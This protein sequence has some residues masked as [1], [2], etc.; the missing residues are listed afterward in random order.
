MWVNRKWLDED[1]NM[2]P[3]SKGEGSENPTLFNTVYFLLLSKQ[4]GGLTETER[5]MLILLVKDK[6]FTNG[7]K[8]KTNNND[9]DD[10]FSLDESMAVATASLLF[11]TKE[12][13]DKLRIVTKQTWFRFYDVI[14]YLLMCKY[15]WTR[16]FGVLQFLV[17]VF[18]AISCLADPSVTSGKQL[19]YVKCR[20]LKMKITYK[21]CS[22]IL[23]KKGGWKA[24]FSV[25]YPEEYHPINIL[26]RNIDFGDL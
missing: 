5:L 22:W 8:Y 26:A 19:A 14:P 9:S 18:S 12:N 6:W 17:M 15:K 23:S 3:N 2:A 20:G 7:G 21:L 24:V 25:Y 16:Y 4:N 13:M 1:G 11:G 10:S